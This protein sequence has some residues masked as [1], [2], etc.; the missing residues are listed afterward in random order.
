MN[1]SLVN[2]V[3]NLVFEKFKNSKRLIHILGV[4]KL[5]KELAIKFGLDADKAYVTGLLHDFCKYET[6][7]EMKKII[8]DEQ[9]IKKF[10]SAPQ[11]Y[12]A[13]AA[14]AWVKDNLEIEDEEILN[15]IKYHVY[16]RTGMSLFEK[17]IVLS[18]YCED[19]REYETCK[20]VRRILNDD[21][22]DLAMYLC[23]KYTIESVLTH[24]DKPLPEQYEILNELEK[25][26]RSFT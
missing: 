3:E 9:I 19:S 8:N 21:K 20:K 5:A 12:H 17:I 4:A 18:D 6:L 13:Y 10:E 23:I 26:I 11:I 2:K 16:G 7:D 22:F 15:G 25:N 14:S 1:Q 24:G